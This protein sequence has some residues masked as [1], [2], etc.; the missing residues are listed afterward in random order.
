MPMQV[1]CRHCNR[2]YAIK[3][4][5]IH[6]AMDQ[7]HAEG[8]KHYNSYCTHC[9]KTN[10]KSGKELKRFAPTWKPSEKKVEKEEEE[11]EE[12]E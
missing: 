8:L 3:N 11:K 9:G 6:A 4:E 10:R 7:I 2:P 5:E 12:K 1:R